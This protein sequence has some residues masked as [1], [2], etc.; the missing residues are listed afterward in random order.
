MPHAGWCCNRTAS[1]N[2]PAPVRGWRTHE[3]PPHL[4]RDGA[5][6]RLQR[7]HHVVDAAGLLP[8]GLEAVARRLARVARLGRAVHRRPAV[9]EAGQQGLRGG[10]GKGRTEIKVWIGAAAAAV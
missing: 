7:A 10:V 8:L 3:Q 9:Q 1:R 2:D 5:V 6:L 4:Q